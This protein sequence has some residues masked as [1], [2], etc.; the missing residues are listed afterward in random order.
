[1]VPV[2]PPGP[3]RPPKPLLLVAVGRDDRLVE[4]ADALDRRAA[5]GE[6]R[7]PDHLRLA[8]PRAEIERRDRRILATAGARGPALQASPD[9]TAERLRL[10]VALRPL[11]ERLEPALRRQDVVVDERDQRRPGLAQ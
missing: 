11:E 2:P 10:G 6:V 7:A 4:R 8:V 3:P 5:D 9:R 1:M